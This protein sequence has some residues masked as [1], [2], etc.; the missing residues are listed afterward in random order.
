MDRKIQDYYFNIFL[1]LLR[2]TYMNLEKNWENVARESGLTHAQ[3]HALWILKFLDGLTLEQLGSIAL[4]NKSTTSALVSR[5]EKKGYIKKD[6]FLDNS[7][8][9]KIHITDQGKSI[10][11]ESLATKTAFEFMGIFEHFDNSELESFLK[12]LH[13]IAD[14]VGTW[15]LNDFENFLEISS[16]KLL[17]NEQMS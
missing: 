10:V 5:L 12:T 17:K 7:R 16:S 13:K 2:A 9:I 11:E 6:K 3:Q 4:W 14:L 15:N 1:N 8:V